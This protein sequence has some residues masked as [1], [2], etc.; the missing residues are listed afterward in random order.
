MI[1]RLKYGY[2]AI[3]FLSALIYGIPFDIGGFTLR[4]FLG[5]VILITLSDLVKSIWKLENKSTRNY[6]LMGLLNSIV[7]FHLALIYSY[8][9][10]ETQ[11][12]LL[13]GFALGAVV[14]LLIFNRMK[15]ML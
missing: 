6:V 9:M 2:G 8:L 1:N 14:Y 3:L 15:Q 12:T 7:F 13:I 11:T 5:V 10:W 4:F